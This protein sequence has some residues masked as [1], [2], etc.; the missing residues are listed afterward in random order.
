MK[1]RVLL[2]VGIQPHTEEGP[3]GHGGTRRHTQA[4]RYL[5]PA[6][7]LQRCR[8]CARG[9]IVSWTSDIQRRTR[10]WQMCRSSGPWSQ[11]PL[12]PPGT[13]VCDSLSVYESLE[14]I[15]ECSSHSSKLWW[16][17]PTRPSPRSLAF[18]FFSFSCLPSSCLSASPLFSIF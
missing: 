1:C 14:V 6:L 10:N 8:W 11:A 7:F 5:K 4:Q 18:I 13:Q 15:C 3:G 16:P 17:C 9:G 2:I 12:S